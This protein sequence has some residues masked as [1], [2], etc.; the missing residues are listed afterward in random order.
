MRSTALCSAKNS[1]LAGAVAAL[2]SLA[3]LASHAQD[4]PPDGAGRISYVSGNVS[5]QPMG[6][7]AWGQAVPNLPFSV[8]DRIVTNG[9]GR[10]EVQVGQS[11]VRIGPN[12]DVS[13]ITHNPRQISFGVA[14]GSVHIHCFGLWE[15]Q[16][17]GVDTPSGAA[18]S[19]GP[20]EFRVD[21]MPDQGAAVITELG[22]AIHLLGAGGFDQYLSNGQALELVG[23]NPVVPQWLQ[24]AEFDDLDQWSRQRDQQI[25]RAAAYQYV[26]REIPGAYEMDAA[27]SWT[28][29]TPYGT[30]WFPNNVEAGWAPYHHG[31]WVNHRPW[32][33]VWVE[34]ESWGYAP[35]HYGRWVSYNGRWGWIPGPPAAHPVWSP[36]L[37]VFA[38]GIHVGGVG[39]SAW[40]PLGPGEP[41]H[42]W[43]PCSPH[44][45]DQVNIA[46]I[47]PA[48][49]V[50]VQN[51]YVNVNVT[52]ITYV[53]RTTIIAVNENDFASGRPVQQAR[54]TVDA[55]QV[56]HVQPMAAPQVKPTPQSF[57][58]HAPAQAVR[59]SAARPVLINSS[60]MAVSATP[61]AKPVPP[62]VKAPPAVKALPGRAAVAPPANAAKLQPAAAEALKKNPPPPPVALKP[63]A[64]PAAA[65]GKTPPPAPAVAAKPGAPAAAPKAAAQPA[66]KAPLKPNE[67]A[68]GGKTGPEGKTTPEGKKG[69]EDKTGSKP[70]TTPPART[71]ATKP[72]TDKT[73]TDKTGTAKPE[74]KT[75]TG[76]PDA[77]KTEKDKKDG[78]NKNKDD[79]KDKDKKDNPGTN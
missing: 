18:G 10:A 20:N 79:D 28:P 48:P 76:K 11:F 69:P 40:F 75:G 44:Y 13:M 70:G 50:H 1:L 24:P 47:Q 60:G 8:G 41:Y 42:P 54:V 31:H 29:G 23:S 19:S 30:V 67:T 55:A 71:E 53:N 25:A 78:K 3:P 15:G 17:L 26:S 9:D 61:N 38:G 56:Q 37:V 68:P 66:G 5:V 64:T 34:D 6:E 35:F 46:N 7:D 72:G 4:D 52:N 73:G 36:A 45:I 21:V 16:Y 14:Q 27:G 58:G 49:Q 63:A 2:L 51:T 12:S 43:Y 22:Q 65:A 62:P 32:G 33:W 59:V 74:T 39:V 77:N 57:I